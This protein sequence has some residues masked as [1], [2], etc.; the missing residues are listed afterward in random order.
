MRNPVG[1]MLETD[2]LDFIKY[3]LP[4]SKRSDLDQLKGWI[5]GAI[6]KLSAL[7]ANYNKGIYNFVDVFDFYASNAVINT[8]GTYTTDDETRWCLITPV[9]F[10]SR[11]IN[12][13]MLQYVYPDSVELPPAIGFIQDIPISIVKSQ[14]ANTTV[15]DANTGTCALVNAQQLLTGLTFDNTS[16]TWQNLLQITCVID[17]YANVIF[18]AYAVGGNAKIDVTDNDIHLALAYVK[19]LA[20][21]PNTPPVE[22]LKQIQDLEFAIKYQM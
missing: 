6:T 2:F 22:T 14:N 18:P 19:E 9:D 5:K 16:N 7:Y 20:Y 17:Y 21:F 1:N 12:S 11:K 4:V 8:R 10:Y 13:C 15:P 3:G